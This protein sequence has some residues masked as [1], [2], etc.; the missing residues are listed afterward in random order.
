MVITGRQP[1]PLMKTHIQFSCD[2]SR[3]CFHM[4]DVTKTGTIYAAF[5]TPLK[6]RICFETFQPV[7]TDSADQVRHLQY[8]HHVLLTQTIE[9]R[10]EMGGLFKCGSALLWERDGPIVRRGGSER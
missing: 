7:K 3:I 4:T 1:G 9:T 10:G 6:T 5:R 2:R 8:C